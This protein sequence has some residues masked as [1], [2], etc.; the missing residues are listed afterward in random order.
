[1]KITLSET[2]NKR[3]NIEALKNFETLSYLFALALLRANYENASKKRSELV[4]HCSEI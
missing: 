1:M 3:N 2:H 4:L